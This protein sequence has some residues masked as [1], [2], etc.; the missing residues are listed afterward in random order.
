MYEFSTFVLI[1]TG[2][3]FTISYLNV[4]QGREASIEG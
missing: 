4:T 1:L 3:C 2:V